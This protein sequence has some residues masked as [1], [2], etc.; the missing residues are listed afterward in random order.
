M[1]SQAQAAVQMPVMSTRSVDGMQVNLEDD[2]AWRNFLGSLQRRGQ[3]AGAAQGSEAY[4]RLL[5]EAQTEFQRWA[6]YERTTAELAAPADC[7]DALLQVPSLRSLRPPNPILP[8][9][10]RC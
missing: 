1:D 2:P 7:V 8:L 5:S 10:N 3:F 6:A 9:I 4:R